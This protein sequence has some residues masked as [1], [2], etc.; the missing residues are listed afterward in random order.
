MSGN[1]LKYLFNKKKGTANQKSSSRP[2]K[3]NHLD[4]EA[5]ESFKRA[6]HEKL[7][8]PNMAKKAA[9]IISEMLEKEH[10]KSG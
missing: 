7:K 3:D 2:S 10:K 4:K 1:K 6:I 8:D 5:V 9:F